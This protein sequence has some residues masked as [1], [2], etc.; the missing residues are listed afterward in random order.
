MLL[1][2]KKLFNVSLLANLYLFIGVLISYFVGKYIQFPIDRKKK[3]YIIFA[4]VMLEISCLAMSIFALKKIVYLTLEASLDMSYQSF[5][6]LG[7]TSEF[8][9]PLAV[10]Y[11]L[12]TD[13]KQ[14]IDYLFKSEAY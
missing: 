7:R 3:K 4:E 12:D 13:L 2:L 10:L 8:F 9:I 6:H 11:F 1:I 5:N 14:K